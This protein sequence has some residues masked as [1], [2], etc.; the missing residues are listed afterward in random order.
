MFWYIY[1]TRE[2]SKEES[3]SLTIFVWTFQF[4]TFYLVSVLVTGAVLDRY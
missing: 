3:L 1:R 4:I 2:V